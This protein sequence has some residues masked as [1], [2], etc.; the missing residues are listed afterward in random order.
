[1]TGCVT[2]AR[3]DYYS[4]RLAADRL[5]RCYEL[6]P[7]RVRQYLAAEIGFVLEYLAPGA[8]VLE[9]GCGYGRVLEPLRARGRMAIGVDIALPSLAAARRWGAV[10]PPPLAAMTALCLGFPDRAFDLV[11]CIQ[12]GISAF[13]VDRLALLEEALRVTRRGG[14]ALFSTYSERFWEWRLQ[15][16]RL[17][18]E[19]GLVGEIDEGA[20]GNG[21]IV[22]RDG[23]R[24]TTVTPAEWRQ[25][26]ERLGISAELVEVDGSSLFCVLRP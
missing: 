16:F 13:G 9:L 21:V 2:S 24:A 26:A 19:A 4:T 1:M 5:R 20:T 11:A 6:A 14:I 3:G 10:S 15:W 25:L 22:C 23:F 17:Q 12:N 8:T 7:P 18:A